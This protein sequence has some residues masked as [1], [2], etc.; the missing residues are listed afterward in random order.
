VRVL[1]YVLEFS[2]RVYTI[3]YGCSC[4]LWKVL[5][6]SCTIQHPISF[7]AVDAYMNKTNYLNKYIYIYIHTPRTHFLSIVY[8]TQVIT[9]RI[10]VGRHRIFHSLCCS[11]ASQLFLPLNIVFYLRFSTQRFQYLLCWCIW[12]SIDEN[13]GLMH[14]LCSPVIS[15]L[16][17]SI[18][19]GFG[20]C[21]Y[22]FTCW[23]KS[24]HSCNSKT[25]YLL[26][27]STP[28]ALK[29][30]FATLIFL[31]CAACLE[32]WMFVIFTFTMNN[33]LLSHTIERT[34][35]FVYLKLIS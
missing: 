20:R 22:F 31:V 12:I 14:W 35:L 16:F 7:Q 32:E 29:S 34:T 26:H 27:K 19:Q 6:I 3:P 11:D 2:H 4:A 33:V 1:R 23:R 21:I 8:R 17:N 13:T 15:I 24:L 5:L 18:E 25:Y 30:L 9:T 10:F 28:L